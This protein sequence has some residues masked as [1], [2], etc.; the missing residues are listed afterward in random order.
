MVSEVREYISSLTGFADVRLIEAEEN[1][2]LSASIIHGVTTTVEEFGRAIILEDDLV[3]S[4]HFLDYM[5]EA[6]RMY[7]HDEAVASIHGYSFPC[8]KE[9]PETF[10]LRGADCW[11]WATWKR[12][13]DS[14]CN[15]AEELLSE[16]NRRKLRREFDFNGAYGYTKMLRNQVL[17]RID[18][19]D[20]C[21]Y[22]SAFLREKLTLFP[23]RSLVRNIG[24]GE[25][26]T[27]AKGA[28]H[29]DVSDPTDVEIDLQRIP[30]CASTEGFAAFEDFLRHNVPHPS[31]AERL[32]TRF[33]RTLKK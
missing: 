8:T 27:H 6:L 18:S 32:V 30:V 5:N 28:D 22:A 33:K 29:F 16:L 11:G 9:L 25:G 26:A 10:F 15:N 14:F 13:W 7:E 17:G 21:W 19:W 24:F 4:R 1:H 23:G 2:G 20:I 3:V 31:L 12:G